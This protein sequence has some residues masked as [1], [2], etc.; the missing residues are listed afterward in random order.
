MHMYVCTYTAHSTLL[1]VYMAVWFSLYY[2]YNARAQNAQ[3][4]LDLMQRIMWSL[5]SDQCIIFFQGKLIQNSMP[6]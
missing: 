3:K 4:M 2:F 6:C 1:S 5:Y